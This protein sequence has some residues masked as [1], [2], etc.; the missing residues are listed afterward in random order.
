MNYNSGHNILALFNNSAQ[1][2][3]ATSKT[4]L[5]ISYNKFGARVA[6][7]VAKRP[8]FP[9]GLCAHTRKKKKRPKTLDLRKLGNIRK[10][11]NLRG[12]AA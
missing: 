3:I 6:S 2:R 10:M 12:D 4:I 1:V 8:N 7:R 11:S 5:D 9:H